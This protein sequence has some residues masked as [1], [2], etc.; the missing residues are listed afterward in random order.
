MLEHMPGKRLEIDP[1]CYIHPSAVVAGDVVLQEHCSVHCNAVLRGDM[2]KIVIGARCNI[3]DG[4]I[5]HVGHSTAGQTVS[6]R[7]VLGDAVSVAHGAIVH[8]CQVGNSVLIAMGAIVMTGAVI[9]ENSIIAA[10]AVVPEGTIVPPG[11]MVMGIPGRVKRTLSAEEIEGI[12][13]VSDTYVQWCIERRE[14]GSIF[15]DGKQYQ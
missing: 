4:A 13:L 8:G 7:I 10:G 9:G 1:S 14:E 15:E 11:S 3:Q 6:G 2:E 12:R 5:L